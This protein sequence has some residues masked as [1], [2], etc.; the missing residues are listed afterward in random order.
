MV[1]LFVEMWL[2]YLLRCGSSVKMWLLYLLRCGYS[3]K[4]WLL[5]LLRCEVLWSYC[6]EQVLV[7]LVHDPSPSQEWSVA[8]DRGK[9]GGARLVSQLW[10]MV[11]WCRAYPRV[12]VCVM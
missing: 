8:L 6:L 2:L 9:V 7:L 10:I 12:C 1:T 3:V 4:M 5:Y 11:V